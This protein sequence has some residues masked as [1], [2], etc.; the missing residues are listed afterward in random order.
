M[1]IAVENRPDLRIARSQIAFQNHNYLYQKA[2]AKPDISIGAEY[3]QRSSYAPNYVGLAVSFPLVIFNKNQGNISSAQFTTRQQQASYD[4]Q[5]SKVE[6]DISMV[7]NKLKYYQQ[8]NNLEQL[9]FSQ[10][11]QLLFQNTLKSY[12]QRQIS[13]LEF[14]DFADAYKD[15]RLKI[16]DQHSGLIKACIELNYLAGKDVVILN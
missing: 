9:A 11:Y 13:L 4:G 6:N 5:L 1:Q 14:I 16:L 12:Q 8:L 15:T 10:Q 2:L 3:D 7:Y